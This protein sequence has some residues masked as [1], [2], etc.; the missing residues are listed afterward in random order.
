MAWCK[1]CGNFFQAFRHRTQW[2]A[3]NSFIL[4]R[5]VP[6]FKKTK[7]EK[8]KRSILQL[9]NHYSCTSGHFHCVLCNIF[10]KEAHDAYE[11]WSIICNETWR[12]S[13]KYAFY[14]SSIS[15]CLAAEWI[16]TRFELVARSFIKLFI[17][18]RARTNTHQSVNYHVRR[19]RAGSWNSF[20]SRLFTQHSTCV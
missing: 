18:D 15:L 6:K 3:W 5:V 2:P 19:N 4:M 1:L 14:V 7:M 20:L 11:L 16:V 8:N 17:L 9:T 12:I 13:I 10:C